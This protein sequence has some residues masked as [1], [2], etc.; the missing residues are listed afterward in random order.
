MTWYDVNK[1]SEICYLYNR[2]FQL[3]WNNSLFKQIKHHWTLCSTH[4]FLSSFKG[5]QMSVETSQHT[6]FLLVL[7][8][9]VKTSWHL[10]SIHQGLMCRSGLRKCQTLT[11]KVFEADIRSEEVPDTYPQSVWG[12]HQVW[13]SVRH[14]P[15]KCLRLTSGLRKCEILTHKVFEAGVGSEEVWDTYPQ[16][17]WGWRRVWGSG[18]EIASWRDAAG[19]DC[20]TW[21]RSR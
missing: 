19:R 2:N 12:W 17:V 16:S 4:L 18:A 21:W 7:S 20:P 14:L 3:E 13:G 11:H 15:T 5:T 1:I 8:A 6:N 9:G 10:A